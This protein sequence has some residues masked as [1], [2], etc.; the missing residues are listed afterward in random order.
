MLT[1]KYGEKLIWGG[2]MKRI[3]LWKI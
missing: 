3:T 1:I 2:G